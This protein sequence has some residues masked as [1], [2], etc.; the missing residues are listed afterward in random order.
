MR[1]DEV[2][3]PATFGLE[4]TR[5]LCTGSGIAAR[6]DRNATRSLSGA[7]RLP[8]RSQPP[9]IAEHPGSRLH[10]DRR[11]HA[12]SCCMRSETIRF[13]KVGRPIET[14]VLAE[15]HE[16]PEIVSEGKFLVSSRDPRLQCLLNRL[17]SMEAHGRI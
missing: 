4:R 17:L 7:E 6:C 1:P 11:C 8:T 12:N 5:V 16:K 9:P 14:D 13:G 3:F 15:L 2:E 10:Q